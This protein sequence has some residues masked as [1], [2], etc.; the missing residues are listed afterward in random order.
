LLIDIH[1]SR[2]RNDQNSKPIEVDIE[3]RKKVKIMRD[4]SKKAIVVTANVG[5]TIGADGPSKNW[6]I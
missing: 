4:T 1:D 6:K 5:R 3:I 2:C